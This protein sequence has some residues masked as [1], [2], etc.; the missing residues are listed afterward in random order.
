MVENS[1]H[2]STQLL[3]ALHNEQ[4]ALQAAAELLREGELVAFPTETVYGL[5]ARVNDPEMIR[6][7]Y[8]A[9]GRPQ[10][11]PLIVHVAHR[12]QIDKLVELIPGAATRLMDAFF[13]GP[14]TLVLPKS[15]AVPDIV[16]A[17]LPGVAVRMPDH[18][19]ARALI[20]A[21]GVPLVAPSANSSGRPSP[22]KA[23]HVLHDLQGRIAAVLDG[24]PCREGLEST[25][26][27]FM[28]PKPVLLRPGVVRAET[29][30]DILG[31]E[32][33][34]ADRLQSHRPESPGMKYK[35]YAPSIPVIVVGPSEWRDAIGEN[36]YV[37]CGIDLILPVPSHS[38]DAPGYYHHLRE[39]ERLGYQR[40]VVVCTP[41]VEQNPALMERIRKSSNSDHYSS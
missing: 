37:L 10:D 39:A 6:Q 36:S 1:G 33:V 4:S 25:V 9:K 18:E 15:A 8:T 13:P 24:G 29:L 41:Q 28:H 26:V 23:A 21:V 30:T 22:T 12:S 27:S 16:T 14:L 3:D 31:E 20:T 17:G 34:L 32:I 2:K 11:N 7:I 35:H 38:L 5:G 19:I 40:V